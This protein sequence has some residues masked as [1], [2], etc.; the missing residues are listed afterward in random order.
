M[1]LLRS[2]LFSIN[3]LTGAEASITFSARTFA[4][5]SSATFQTVPLSFDQLSLSQELAFGAGV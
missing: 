3:S 2:F 1:R 4:P 5:V